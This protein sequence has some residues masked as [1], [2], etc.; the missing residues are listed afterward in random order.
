MFMQH[1]QHK[2]VLIG[3]KVKLLDPA[4]V[5]ARGYTLTYA[6]GKVVKSSKELKAGEKLTTQFKDGQV[7]SKI[8][9]I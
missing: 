6:N 8:T 2:I 9:E 7:Q 4:H 5:I 1:Q 3:E